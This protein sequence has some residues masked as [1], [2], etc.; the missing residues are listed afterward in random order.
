MSKKQ[1]AGLALALGLVCAACSNSSAPV[2][3]NDGAVGDGQGPG[4]YGFLSDGALADL[5]N[6]ATGMIWNPNNQPACTIVDGVPV[7]YA[8]SNGK[9]DDGDGLTDAQDPECMGPCDNDEGSF[10][11]GI[12]GDNVDACKQDCF[13]DGN[14]GQGDDGCE[15]NLKCDSKS[16]GANLAKPCP[17]VADFKNC[18]STQT[19]TCVKNCG[20][21]T[22]NGCDCFGCCTVFINHESRTIY[23]GSGPTCST[24][25]PQNCSSCTQVSSCL[26][27]CGECELCL[28]K[29]MADLPAK[30]FPPKPDSGV[31]TKDSGTVSPPPLPQCSN[32]RIPCLGNAN[33]PTNYYCVT[34]C[35]TLSLDR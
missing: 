31:A 6:P 29:T 25:T 28:G 19:E 16:P 11:T 35:C 23:L 20:G 3:T 13:F 18:P 30:C 14:S 8:C 27:P 7:I 9:D 15:W 4:G 12:P 32:G 2:W 17:Y 1:L 22:P 10:A 24:A 5:F 33:C 26:N 34:G 21:R